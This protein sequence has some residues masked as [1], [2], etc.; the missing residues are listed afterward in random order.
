M[1]R[2]AG[3]VKHVGTMTVN[4]GTGAATLLDAVDVKGFRSVAL[5]YTF[6][7]TQN[8]N[9]S[10]TNFF[11]I[12][13]QHSDT[14]GGTYVDVPKDALV[15]SDGKPAT[16]DGVIH[17]RTENV[18][19][20]DTNGVGWYLGDKQFVRVRFVPSGSLPGAIRARASADL[21]RP[22]SSHLV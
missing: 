17:K 13:V 5:G 22:V 7:A 1:Q 9:L 10:T 8:R 2:T 20:E 3:Y 11:E 4:S 15:G 16:A 14:S 6:D 18:G 19:T 21:S 12:K